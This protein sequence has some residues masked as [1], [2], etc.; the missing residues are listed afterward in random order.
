M[1][2]QGQYLPKLEYDIASGKSH[3][4]NNLY[5]KIPGTRQYVNT[6]TGEIASE[7]Y[8][9]RI[10]RPNLKTQRPT[11]KKRSN[12]KPYKYQSR[13]TR[14]LSQAEPVY[15]RRLPGSR[16]YY[17]PKTGEIVTEDY[18]V[19]HYRP[20]LQEAQ[21]ARI[22]ERG[23]KQAKATRLITQDLY[24]SWLY[25]EQALATLNGASPDEL[26]ELSALGTKH[27]KFIDA[28]I[29][30]IQSRLEINSTSSADRIAG[31]AP[32]SRYANALVELGR[33]TPDMDEPVGMSP[34][35]SVSEI[36]QPYYDDL[37]DNDYIPDDYDD[38]D[39]DYDNDYP[40]EEY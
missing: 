14:D 19:R 27:P 40:Y 13:L 22:R 24:E 34:P 38:Y 25:K 1:G 20:A 2:Y 26:A 39:D 12:S 6:L 15:Y 36:V 28:Q 8:V 3:H 21:R 5:R 30:L 31:T 17:H 35:G 29:E 16:N 11:T 10:Y 37:L 23:Y 33:R 4:V 7:H 9:V 18:V 32:D